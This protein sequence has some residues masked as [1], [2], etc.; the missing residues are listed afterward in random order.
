V[1]VR[2][3][4]ICADDEPLRLVRASD[5]QRAPNVERPAGHDAVVGV[6]EDC[7]AAIREGE[8][9]LGET[10]LAADLHRDR[11]ATDFEDGKLVARCESTA[12]DRGEVRL[13]MDEA[14]A[15]RPE[16]NCLVGEQGSG[17]TAHSNPQRHEGRLG[18]GCEP[19]Y[20]GDAAARVDDGADTSDV[21]A[22]P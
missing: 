9:L 7:S 6:E 3:G 20:P 15:V 18:R 19:I 12:L 5:E 16:T 21:A 1:L 4:S 10:G 22:R 8:P 11:V 14:G 13:A 17:S 2:M